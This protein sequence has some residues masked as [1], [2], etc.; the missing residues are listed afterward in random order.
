VAGALE[1]RV[2]LERFDLQCFVRTSGS[3]GLHV[4]VPLK[5]ALEW[6]R[7]RQFARSIA[8]SMAADDPQRYLA[9]AAK[10][11]R[12]GK[13]FLDYLRNARGATAVCSY[14]LRARPGAPLATP[15]T[16]DELPRVTG[17][18]QFRF[19]NILEHLAR[20]PVPAWQGFERVT[21]SLPQLKARAGRR[22]RP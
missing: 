14:S 1:L 21:Q 19:G 15:L 2:R 20:R 12:A 8:E 17:A 7:V 6:D 16:W 9:V 22:R 10:E 3:K 13:I 11:Q 18:D 4:V 5:P